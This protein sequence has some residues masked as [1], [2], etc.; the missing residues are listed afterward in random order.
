MALYK[1]TAR[2]PSGKRMTGVQES[3][4]TDT[5]LD[6]LSSRGYIVTKIEPTTAG[7]PSKPFLGGFSIGGKIKEEQF[8][9]FNIQLSNMIEAGLTLLTALE[10]IITQVKN[11]KFKG[12]LRDVA[13]SIEGGKS[14]SESASQY[15]KVFNELFTTLVMVGE[16]SGTLE[17]ILNRYAKLLEDQFELK[18]KVKSAMMYPIILIIVSILIVS[19]MVTMV[20]PNFVKIFVKSGVPLPWPTRFL[21][22][23]SQFARK[24]W[25]V[26]AIICILLLIVVNFIKKTPWGKRWFNALSLRM[27]LFGSLNQ[28]VIMS[29]WGRTLGTLIGGGVPIMQALIISKRVAQNAVI[30]AGLERASQAVEKGARLGDTLKE[31]KEFPVEV[32]Q[33]I[34]VGEESGTLDKMLIKMADFYDKLIGYQVKRLSEMIEPTFLIF[35]GGI[36]GFIMLSMLLPIFDMIQ[37]IQTRGV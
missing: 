36:V 37:A 33:M 18:K 32:V 3:P 15:P 22:G 14:F 24:Y 9:F 26:I 8:I 5:L 1:Y 7:A 17:I 12:V 30:E 29:R 13:N 2:D 35:V 21:Y 34:N 31:D 4:D 25:L 23:V 28:K 11:K 19:L 27:P 16:T 10:N 20:V 6:R